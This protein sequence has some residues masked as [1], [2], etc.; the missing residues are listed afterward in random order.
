MS[1]LEKKQ[2][3]IFKTIIENNNKFLLVNHIRMD[4]DAFGSLGAF[5]LLLKKLGKE[6]RATN[7]EAVPENF[8]FLTKED[9]IILYRRN[10]TQDWQIVPSTVTG[11]SYNGTLIVNQILPGEYLVAV[12][13]DQLG[14]EDSNFEKKIEI[15]PNPATNTL[16]YT[17][18]HQISEDTFLE[19]YDQNCN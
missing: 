2:V 3:D 7:D 11:N 13:N 6:V 5:Y 15:Y 8:S 19:I 1:L 18:Y 10:A 12:G 16:F 17:I 4:P 9:L 14:M